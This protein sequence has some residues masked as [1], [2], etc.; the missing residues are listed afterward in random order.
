ME[1]SYI[2]V[3]SNWLLGYDR[4]KRI[5]SKSNLPQSTYPE[6]F[7]LLKEDELY[8]GLKKANALLDKI[9][10]ENK[11]IFSQNKIIKINTKIETYVY[12][13]EKNGLGWFIN[14]KFIDVE[15]VDIYL[16][17]IWT[18]ITIEDLTAIAFNLKLK[19][20]QDYNSLIPMSLSFLPIAMAC[21]AKCKFCFSESSISSEQKK[22]VKDFEE[23]EYW[24]ER[25]KKEGA[26]RFVIT[27][28]GEPG[29]LGLEKIKEIL[30]IS[31]KYFNKNILFTNGFFISKSENIKETVKELKS[32]GLSILSLSCHH[33][34]KEKLTEIM[35]IDTGYLTILDEI[36]NIPVDERPKIRLICVIQ[37]G[38][39][40]N[41]YE[42]QKY[43]DFAFDNNIEQ[44]CFKE[45]Y[46]AAT[47]ESLYS[48][49]KENKYCIEHQVSLS[50]VIDYAKN[51]GLNKVGELAWGS[52]IYQ[53]VK[54]GKTL[55]IAA[56]TEPS[57]GWER[58]NGKA[59]SW[60]YMANKKCYASLEDKNSLLEKE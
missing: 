51:K 19:D 47:N 4:Y 54:E 14:Q 56:Y 59:R 40:D 45:L 32:S 48:K 60:N 15:S 7:Y 38:G 23:L 11:T 8:I 3:L 44:I 49:T 6:I 42:I 58:T 25:A 55:D 37:K 17:G 31:K 41:F 20:Y 46:V 29:I 21:E 35:G 12:K 16:N 53:E 26:Q 52:P 33:Y 13:N 10:N 30:S 27:G 50:E 22:K 34:Q 9:N 2:T 28:G 36:K 5:Y 24:C 18:S 39:I 57:V 43:V 1:Y